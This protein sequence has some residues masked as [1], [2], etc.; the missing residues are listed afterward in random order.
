MKEQRLEITLQIKENHIQNPF[1]P[2]FFGG[3]GS[4]NE[5]TVHPGE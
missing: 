2:L 4:R 5:V 3:E 1:L